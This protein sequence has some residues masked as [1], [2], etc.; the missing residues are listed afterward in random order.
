MAMYIENTK[1]NIDLIFRFIAPSNRSSSVENS[2]YNAYVFSYCLGLLSKHKSIHNFRD[3]EKR[4]RICKALCISDRTYYRYVEEARKYGFLFTDPNNQNVLR[5]TGVGSLVDIQNAVIKEEMEITDEKVLANDPRIKQFYKAKLRLE[6]TS[7][8]HVKT[9]MDVALLRYCDYIES[10]KRALSISSHIH[11]AYKKRTSDS[12]F[13]L[14]YEDRSISGRSVV[15]S[16]VSYAHRVLYGTDIDKV[17]YTDSSKKVNGSLHNPLFEK[18]I[19]SSTLIKSFNSAL[20]SVYDFYS[21]E[22]IDSI[23][24]GDNGSKFKGL[25]IGYTKSGFNSFLERAES[26]G[27]VKRTEKFV[28]VKTYVNHDE[29]VAFKRRMLA[30][31]KSMSCELTASIV[32]RFLYRHGCVVMQ[33]ENHLKINS[34]VIKFPWDSYAYASLVNENS[35]VYNNSRYPNLQ[36]KFKVDGVDSEKDIAKK[37]RNI[38]I[39]DKKEKRKII[40]SNGRIFTSLVRI[41]DPELDIFKEKARDLRRNGAMEY[42]GEVY[43]VYAKGTSSSVLT[44]KIY[45]YGNK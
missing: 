41:I 5:I 19:Y 40:D 32:N 16:V 31:A 25:S 20:I 35:D 9:V 13:L 4:Q 18:R 34:Q 10:L 1:F 29:Y 44:E 3:K 43:K 26:K 2:R 33:R 23:Y 42:K 38:D 7:F 39:Y 17:V 14:T 30:Y 6:N 21:V 27:L 12:N 15:A 8:E 28:I 45:E 24:K 11:K 37:N 22:N 36:I